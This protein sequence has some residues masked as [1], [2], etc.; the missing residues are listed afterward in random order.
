MS[1]EYNDDFDLDD[2]DYGDSEDDVESQVVNNTNQSSQ[3][4][5]NNSQR[6][7][8]NSQ[9]QQQR[10]RGGGAQNRQQVG[11]GTRQR[12]QGS[13]RSRNPQRPQGSQRTSNPNERS[14]VVST[15]NGKDRARVHS[16]QSVNNPQVEHRSRVIHTQ[17][18][19]E[20]VFEDPFQQTPP[21]RKKPKILI[22]GIG[23]VCAI[24][25][26]VLGGKLLSVKNAPQTPKIVNV[27]NS[28]YDNLLSALNNYD[29]S[30]IDSCVGDKDGDSYLAQEWSYANYNEQRENFIKL[31]C[32]KVKF[33]YNQ[34][35]EVD[36][37]G[38]PIVQNGEKVTVTHIDYKALTDAMQA[39]SGTIVGDYNGSS[40]TDK[41]YDFNN[42]ITDLMLK[43]INTKEDLPTKTTDIELKT[44][45]DAYVVD[46]IALDKLLFSSDDFHNM[47]DVY[48][49][50][51]TNFTGYKT[52]T[53]TA[54]VEK[55]N[56]E[57]AKWK[58]KFDAYYKADKGKFHKGVSKWEPWYLRD[59][60]NNLILD[61]KGKKIVNYYSVKD[62]NGNDW[63]QP[64]KKVIVKV[65]K[66]RQV[67]EE[68][69]NDSIIPYCFLGAYY[70]QNEY[71][72]SFSPEVRVGNGTL[73]HPA[74]VNTPIITKCL[75][76]DGKF[77]DVKV[78]LIGYWEDQKAI[79]YVASFSE[80]NRGFDLSSVVQL[81]TY[82]IRVQNLENSTFEFDSDMFLS[83]NNANKATRNGTMFGFKSS[84][85]L[86]PFSSVIVQDWG[87]STELKQKYVC[88]GGSFARKYNVVYFNL[89]AGSG[90]IPTYSAYKA[91]TGYSQINNGDE[92]AEET[93]E[94]EASGSPQ[95]KPV[96]GY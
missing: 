19:D 61:E 85:K 2:F 72:G 37:N 29:A 48:S 92:K 91:F 54:E 28:A 12:P 71:S 88:W 45:G 57:Y 78:T 35:S 25:L 3:P 34:K 59:D 67:P 43:Y 63:I 65:K 46:D 62:E 66:K 6:R 20:R 22:A 87:T 83:D 36:A 94:P 93:P 81:I 7:T 30:K 15:M 74:G 56:P 86:T 53:Y 55:P 44:S 26:V 49:Q 11:G 95:P 17:T 96:Y 33:S 80:K 16:R 69:K 70:C 75:G 21:R 41:D 50:I 84:G 38:K 47:C 32:S 40:I 82:E 31:V 24:G 79:D 23:V 76:K 68:W 51:A 8:Q 10:P 89:L 14:P 42:E 77:H 4:S 5:E 60:N 52:E 13:P 9:H 39:D 58:A 18:E 27:S 64:D 73:E 90:D 1:E